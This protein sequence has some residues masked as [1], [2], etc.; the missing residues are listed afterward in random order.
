[1]SV[2][3]FL[4]YFIFFEFFAWRECSRIM[5]GKSRSTRFAENS[6]GH[7][8]Q[9]S[10]YTSLLQC[11]RDIK[12][13]LW[14]LHVVDASLRSEIQLLWARV[15]TKTNFVLVHRSIRNFNFPPP[16]K[17]NS[18]KSV[19]QIPTPEAKIMFKCLTQVNFFFEKGKLGPLTVVRAWGIGNLNLTCLGN[20]KFELYVAGVGNLNRKCQVFLD[21]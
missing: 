8:M 1:M 16:W 21:G 6:F 19:F 11:T 5:L 18:W 20:G 7:T 10:K 9:S 14:G 15:G 4:F 2:I 17:L 3:N 12:P 13:H